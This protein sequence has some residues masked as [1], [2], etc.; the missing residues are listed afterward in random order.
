MV[1][2]IQGQNN[3]LEAKIKEKTLDFDRQL[4]ENQKQTAA[5]LEQK[6]D[7]EKTKASILNIL[8]DINEE[9]TRAD[10]LAQDLQKF[11]LAVDNASD[12]IAITDKDGVII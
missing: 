1:E 11:K 2:G 5:L 6:D 7:T 4:A 10:F 8:D 9:R 3:S 12:Y